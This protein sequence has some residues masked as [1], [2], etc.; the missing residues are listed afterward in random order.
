[1]TMPDPTPAVLPDTRAREGRKPGYYWVR[2]W[3]GDASRS[4]WEVAE[5]RKAWWLIGYST[6]MSDT[7]MESIGAP[8]S[9]LTA[10]P[11]ASDSAVPVGEPTDEMI[12]AAGMYLDGDDYE[13]TARQVWSAMLAAAPKVA[14]EAQAEIERLRG[15]LIDPGMPPWEDARAVLV[16]ELRKAGLDKR[17]ERV[18]AAQPELIPSDIA[19][20]LLAHASRPKFASEAAMREPLRFLL[21]ATRDY[22]ADA[23]VKNAV[24][25]AIEQAD[26]VLHPS[27]SGASDG[28]EAL[29]AGVKRA[30]QN[31]DGDHDGWTDTGLKHAFFRWPTIVHAI[32]AAL[33]TTPGGDLLEQAARACRN[34][35]ENSA[36][37]LDEHDARIRHEGIVAGAQACERAIRAIPPALDGERN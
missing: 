20:N 16:A 26:R 34:I 27:L 9:P 11:P 35:A 23:P 31:P 28:G 6:P 15:L 29:I 32:N 30:L 22:L 3:E 36:L 7:E 21:A 12:A 24:H 13:W 14:S 19:L 5:W 10:T 4:A 17:A 18:A 8:V 1:M 37:V 2:R 25:F 33:A